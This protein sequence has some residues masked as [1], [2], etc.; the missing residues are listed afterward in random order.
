MS[1]FHIDG[2]LIRQLAALMDE[3]GLNEL[4]VV[5]GERKLRLARGGPGVALA[6]V[7][8]AAPPIM[9]TDTA[10]QTMAG[11]PAGAI[12]SPMVGTAYLAP[13][14][15]ATPFVKPGDRVEEGQTGMIIEAMTVMNPIRAPRAGVV[16]QVLIEDAQPVEFG[17]ILMILD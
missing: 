8:H 11:P 14:P 12:T 10:Q 17:E 13:E 4:E 15:G 5:E 2:D 3:A 7:A 6:P 9:A 16:Q 1:A